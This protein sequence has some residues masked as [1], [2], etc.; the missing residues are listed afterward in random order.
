MRFNPSAFQRFNGFISHPLSP[1]GTMPAFSTIK[2]T[3][4]SGARVRCTSP[5]GT[6][7]PSRGP[8][9]TERSSRSIIEWPS[10]TKTTSSSRSC[11]CQCY[12]PCITPMRTT[13][14]F[15][16]QSV[17]LYHLSLQAFTNDGTSTKVS[18]G[19]LMSRNV[20]YGYD[21]VSLIK[22]YGQGAFWRNLKSFIY[23]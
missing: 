16:F 22:I 8:K 21:F 3:A 13:E 14:S 10:R 11:L 4:R 9:S 15:T 5:F 6:T 1:V 19:N 18:A 17:W 7:N 23:N 12:S 2:I 20:A